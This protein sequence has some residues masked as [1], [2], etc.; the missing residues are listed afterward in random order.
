MPKNVSKSHVFFVNIFFGIMYLYDMISG[1]K[2]VL[3]EIK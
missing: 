3:L 2:H 1:S